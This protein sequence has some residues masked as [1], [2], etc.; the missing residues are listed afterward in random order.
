MESRWSLDKRPYPSMFANPQSHGWSSR[1]QSRGG[2]SSLSVLGC[3]QRS[4]YVIFLS[5]G[6]FM[7]LMLGIGLGLYATSR[8][9]NNLSLPKTS[10]ELSGL[11]VAASL[12]S[13]PGRLSLAQPLGSTNQKVRIKVGNA[14]HS[15]IADFDVKETAD[16]SHGENRAWMFEKAGAEP[17]LAPTDQ[18]AKVEPKHLAEEPSSLETTINTMT[19]SSSSSLSSS[20]FNRIQKTIP[21]DKDMNLSS[22]AGMQE[23]EISNKKPRRFEMVLLATFPRSGSSWTRT[24]LRGATQIKTDLT[25]VK[26]L[27]KLEEAEKMST[28]FDCSDLAMTQIFRQ[29]GVSWLA[30]NNKARPLFGINGQQEEENSCAKTYTKFNEMA[31]QN[32]PYYPRVPPVLIKTHYPQIGDAKTEDFTKKV[33][34]IVHIVRNPFDTIASRFLGNQRQH[35]ERF[36]RLKAARAN[37]STTS[38]FDEFVKREAERV[39]KFYNYWA[40]RRLADAEIGIQTLYLRYEV[41]CERTSLVLDN[42]VDFIGY[43]LVESSHRCTLEK[44]GC[45]SKGDFPT[46]VNLYTDDQVNYILKTQERFLKRHGYEWNAER[47]RIETFNVDVMC[48]FW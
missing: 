42:L 6:L 7:G 45:H 32:W 11:G 27:T 35:E 12:H 39:N 22:C 48:D 38:E 4:V 3:C 37:D 24:L 29:L 19:S 40:E 34:K 18:A 23:L 30:T 26:G 21:L 1:R 15:K 25:T 16:S 9:Q 8:G 41:L 5:T 46:H 17:K 33:S 44:M 10:A 47:H 36:A 2:S 13:G 43:D 20:L 28:C 31:G 14:R